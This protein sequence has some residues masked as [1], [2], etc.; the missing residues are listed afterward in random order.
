MQFLF[1]RHGET[2]WNRQQM[3][4][5]SRDIPLNATGV[6]QA[7][8]AALALKNFPVTKIISSPLSRARQT[9][10]FI[11]AH[12][13]LPVTEDH[14]LKERHYGLNE[15]LVW[16]D[17]PRHPVHIHDPEGPHDFFCNSVE[18]FDALTERSIRAVHRGIDTEGL[19]LFVA[20]G[21]VFSAVHYALKCGP[22]ARSDNAV[23]YRF[24]M[25]N[26]LWVCEAVVK[27]D[28]PVHPALKRHAI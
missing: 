1:I 12:L 11:A 18:R 7:K 24:S 19:T 15:G 16:N 28:M 6:E 13:E 10:E 8:R 21:G 4:Q 20:H 5:G 17:L 23:P 9:A 14:E 26:G 3:L 2:D 27:N 25:T 22:Y